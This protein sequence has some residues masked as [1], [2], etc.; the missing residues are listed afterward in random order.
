MAAP[1][2][3]D[4]ALTIHQD[5][6]LYLASL[7]A[8]ESVVHAMRPDRHAWVQVL[9]GGVR[10]NG[11]AL[12]AGDGAALSRESTVAVEGDGGGEVLLFDL[13]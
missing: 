4:G 3:G 13:A 11:E 2:G 9:R 6:R 7:S 1:D 5:A 12:K 10:V 8:A